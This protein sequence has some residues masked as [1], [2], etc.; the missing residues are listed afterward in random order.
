MSMLNNSTIESV[1]NQFN[2]NYKIF[3]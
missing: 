1:L 2:S 3:E